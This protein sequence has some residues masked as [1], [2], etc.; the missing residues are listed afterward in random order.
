VSM[1]Q[2]V[3]DFPHNYMAQCRLFNSNADGWM[4]EWNR[5]NGGNCSVFVFCLM[6]SPTPI[7]TLVTFRN[8]NLVRNKW[9]KIKDELRFLY[10]KKQKG[11]KQGLGLFIWHKFYP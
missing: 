1:W 3:N 5:C 10:I 2:K 9:I 8:G 6:A 7:Y 11:I 4:N